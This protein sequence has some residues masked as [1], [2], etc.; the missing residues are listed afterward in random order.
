MFSTREVPWSKVGTVIDHPVNAEKAMRI[1]GLD[2]EVLPRPA[3]YL[4]NAAWHVAPE[5][6]A[7]VREDTGEVY[8]YASEDYTPVQYH[9][10]FNFMD[11]INPRYV[12]AGALKGGRQGFLVAVLPNKYQIALDLGGVKDPH[13]LYVLLR[14]SHDLTR[15]IEI[16]LTTLRGKCMNMLTLPSIKA[17]AKQTWAIRH[18]TNVH[19]RLAQAKKIITGADAYAREF[20]GIAQRLA[21][22]DLSVSAQEDILRSVL[23][24]KPTRNEQTA[25][26]LA[27][28]DFETNVEFKGT[29]WGLLNATNE[30]FLYLR[31][32]R[33]RTT[34]SR[35]TN[36]IDGT[37]HRMTRSVMLQTLARHH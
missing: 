29:G 25:D 17:G 23:P 1:G 6:V 4:R 10:A 30:Y 18:T 7:L 5:R 15:G 34:E 32:E 12:A 16:V 19:V 20:E 31:S 27:A 26:I 2:F 35:F 36:G 9:D 3:G 33:A 21:S 28:L 13:D 11:E 22:I 8:G 14:T 24:D 37:A